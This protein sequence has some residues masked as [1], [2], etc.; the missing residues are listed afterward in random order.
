[1]DNKDIL[2]QMYREECYFARHHEELRSRAASLIMAVAAG[3]LGLAALDRRL[4]VDDAPLAVFVVVLGLFGVG[5]TLKSFER[6]HRHLQ[7]ADQYLY[8]LARAAPNTQ[9]ARVRK[10]ARFAHNA[11]FRWL[12]KGP[13][14][15]LFWVVLH[16][17]T[18]LLGVA[19]LLLPLQAPAAAPTSPSAAGAQPARSP[20]S[21]A[22]N[23]EVEVVFWQSIANSTNPAEFEAY[24]AQFPNGVFG[25]L[26]EARLAT[27]R[28]AGERSTRQR[29]RANGR[30]R[31]IRRLLAHRVAG[32]RRGVLAT[33]PELRGASGDSGAA[34]YGRAVG[35][36]SRVV[37]A[38]PASR[39]SPRSTWLAYIRTHQGGPRG[40]RRVEPLLP[41]S[42]ADDVLLRTARVL[43]ARADRGD[44][45]I[46]V[47][48]VTVPDCGGSP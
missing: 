37:R 26:A 7:R 47:S 32:P 30:R 1:M 28:G 16:V 11:K 10:D 3:I 5:F 19:M 40:G 9:L 45:V 41:D 29:R 48:E 17:L 6:G 2:L 21:P 42:T 25:R 4:A 38:P 34:A 35:Q 39:P 13:H 23:S 12:S 15:Y 43:D 31:G 44:A 22:A 24:L 46:G 8:T 14:L 27:L 33:F 36:V 20:G 18:V